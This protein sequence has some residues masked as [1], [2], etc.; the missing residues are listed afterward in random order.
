M[1]CSHSFFFLEQVWAVWRKIVAWF[2]RETRCLYAGGA[3]GA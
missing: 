3:F 1:E 2:G